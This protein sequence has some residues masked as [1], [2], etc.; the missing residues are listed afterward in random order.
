[1]RIHHCLLRC[2]S[3]FGICHFTLLRCPTTDAAAF[4]FAQIIAICYLPLLVHCDSIR[5]HFDRASSMPSHPVLPQWASNLITASIHPSLTRSKDF[6]SNVLPLIP[7]NG[8]FH[9]KLCSSSKRMRF[10]FPPSHPF[11]SSDSR[12]YIHLFTSTYGNIHRSQ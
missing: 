8:P 7:I 1:M 10:A 4:H 3:F 11:M 2:V 12:L 6:T 9:A 5:V